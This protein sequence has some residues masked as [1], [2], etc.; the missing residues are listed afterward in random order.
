MLR[1][2]KLRNRMESD[3]L[4]SR[5]PQFPGSGSPSRLHIPPTTNLTLLLDPSYGCYE[6]RLSPTT[7][8]TDGSPVGTWIDQKS[9]ILFIAPNDSAR[10]IW[11]A[12]SGRPYITFDGVNDLLSCT[13]VGFTMGGAGDFTVAAGF[14]ATGAGPYSVIFG[15]WSANFAL[16]FNAT[17]GKLGTVVKPNS[18]S[19]S[20]QNALTSASVYRDGTWRRGVSMWTNTGYVARVIGD[21]TDSGTYSVGET[22]GSSTSAYVGAQASGPTNFLNGNIGTILVYNSYLSDANLSQLDAYLASLRA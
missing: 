7:P 13:N 10:P 17:G 9:S 8:C 20:E 14:T 18:G 5:M 1:K 12:N 16:R 22:I 2:S 19:P 21:G 15:Y 3:L 11:R 6:E 4:G